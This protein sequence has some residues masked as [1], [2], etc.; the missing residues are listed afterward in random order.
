M[1]QSSMMR[2]LSEMMWFPS[3]FL[4]DNISFEAVDAT[5]ARVTLTDHGRTPPA[6]CSLTPRAGSPTSWPAVTRPSAK[7]GDL[8]TWSTPV[9]GYGE[10]EGLKLPVRVKAVWKFAGGD[11]EDVN[12]TVTELHYDI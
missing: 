1:D 8:E 4:A 3:A 11:L 10:F 7:G 12:V 2:Y 6:P 5:S 9:T